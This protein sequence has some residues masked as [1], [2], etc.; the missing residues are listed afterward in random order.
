[1]RPARHQPEEDRRTK[2]G[3]NHI[4]LVGGEIPRKVFINIQTAG[5]PFTGRQRRADLRKLVYPAVFVRER[6]RQNT[7][8]IAGESDITGA[9]I[10]ALLRRSALAKVRHLIE[11]RRGIPELQVVFV[12]APG[13]ETG[14]K[15]TPDGGVEDLVR[16]AKKDT[17]RGV[18]PFRV[19]GLADEDLRGFLQF[20]IAA[21]TRR[22]VGGRDSLPG[23]ST[24]RVRTF[25]D[26]ESAKQVFTSVPV[27]LIREEAL[28]RAAQQQRPIHGHVILKPRKVVRTADHAVK[29]REI[30]SVFEKDPEDVPVLV[31]RG[32]QR[33]IRVRD[34]RINLSEGTVL[35]PDR[36]FPFYDRP[37]DLEFSACLLAK[38][39]PVRLVI[40]A[41][42]IPG[43]VF[44]DQGLLAV[45]RHERFE[46]IRL[47]EH[48]VRGDPGEIGGQHREAQVLPRQDRGDLSIAETEEITLAVKRK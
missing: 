5:G 29:N 6:D 48:D 18:I 2:L 27:D 28:A 3:L 1:M 35:E 30:L 7:P 17:Q 20:I 41:H 10:K 24:R 32:D 38:A 34:A 31:R 12:A 43:G 21:V 4:H 23:I 15:E 42:N 37:F 25:A 22:G 45:D 26:I 13:G 33:E 46:G 39:L 14:N 40:T 19:R 8:L 9:A 11:S 44:D 36:A 16:C 47:Q